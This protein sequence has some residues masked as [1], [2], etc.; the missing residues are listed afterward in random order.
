ME[1]MSQ[2]MD[3]EL[4][5]Q[6]ARVQIRRI[7][8]DPELARQW[9][10]YH[11]IRD[12]LRNEVLAGTSLTQRVA[13]HLQ[14]EPTVIAPHTRFSARIVRYSLPMAAA[15]AGITVVG[16]LALGLHPSPSAPSQLALQTQ[17]A[18]PPRVVAS[19]VPSSEYY[20]L[21]HREFS[22]T[23]AMQGAASYIRMVSTEDADSPQ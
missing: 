1:K 8:Q 13:A 15:V 4:D 9:E 20:I 14:K 5:A 17:T 10:T 19:A 11:L 16:W 21:A 7:T 22:P 2:M 3:G 23:A 6:E 18:Q 12:A